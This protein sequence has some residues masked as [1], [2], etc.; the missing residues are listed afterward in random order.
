MDKDYPSMKN[1]LWEQKEQSRKLF[2]IQKKKKKQ[3]IANNMNNN[4]Q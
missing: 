3:N 2:L 4:I 1:Q